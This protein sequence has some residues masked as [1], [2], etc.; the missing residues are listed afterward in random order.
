MIK[1]FKDF[2]LR[3]NVIELAVGLVLALALTAVVNALVEHL[4]TPLVA[5]IF[6]Q[7]NLDSVATFTIN[8]AQFSIGAILTAIV[9]FLIIAAAVYFVLIV[10]MNKL[11]E[12]RAAGRE[13]PP[14][15]PT[16]DVILLRE[17]RD[18]LRQRQP[19]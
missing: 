4:I 10:P 12:R 14:E 3:G 11:T 2:I 17:I 5:A 6:G 15:A 8:E 19:G 16:E 18:L 1:G 7:P 13:A 9:N